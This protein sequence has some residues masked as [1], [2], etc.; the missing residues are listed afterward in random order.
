[1]VYGNGGG[2][3]ATNLDGFAVYRL[4]MSGFSVTNPPNTPPVELLFNDESEE[5]DAHGVGV[6]KNERY[7]WVGDRGG[8]VVEVFR[9]LNGNRVA[10]IDLV[11]AFSRDPTPD[12]FAPSPNQNWFFMSTRG[13]TPLSGDPHSSTGTHPG[14]LI[15][16]LTE[17]GRGGEVQGLVRISN[18]DA[19]GFERADP[20]GIAMRQVR[21]E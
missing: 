8:N 6:T 10:T 18:I 19:G 7:V 4:P 1:M 12:L 17:D 21:G 3:T 9:T 14:L 16:R 13:P 15:V 20:H 5:R 11:S 2:A